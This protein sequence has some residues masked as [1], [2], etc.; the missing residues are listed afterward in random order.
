MGMRVA[1]TQ[2]EKFYELVL[3]NRNGQVGQELNV[4][5]RDL[6]DEV[7]FGELL[8]KLDCYAPELSPAAFKLYRD[9]LG[10]AA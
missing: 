1:T 10:A 2:A 8:S 9:L 6:L 3:D 4:M 5:V 7:E